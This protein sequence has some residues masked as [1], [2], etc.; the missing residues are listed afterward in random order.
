MSGR[1]LELHSSAHPCQLLPY[2][3]SLILLQPK[4]CL[5]TFS[6]AL[7]PFSCTQQLP[8]DR[9]GQQASFAD[10]DAYYRYRPVYLLG[11]VDFR[12]DLKKLTANFEARAYNQA[13]YF[14]LEMGR[15]NIFQIL[16]EFLVK[17]WNSSSHLAII[18]GW[19]SVPSEAQ[20]RSGLS[21]LLFWSGLL[22]LPPMIRSEWVYFKCYVT[23]Q[24][25]Q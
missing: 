6:L 16:I 21:L 15:S 13:K 17:Y 20:F 1:S 3:T 18:S 2:S 10:M 25:V 12:L 5:G 14:R 4:L 23:P 9:L 19:K 8:Q 22:C 24:V 7:A 11:W